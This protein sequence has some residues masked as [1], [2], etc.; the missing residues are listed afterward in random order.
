MEASL[1]VPSSLAGCDLRAVSEAISTTFISEGWIN[2]NNFL[3]YPRV[4]FSDVMNVR[5]LIEGFLIQEFNN[6]DPISKFYNAVLG[7]FDVREVY[8]SGKSY[9]LMTNFFILM[10][11]LKESLIFLVPSEEEKIVLTSFFSKL[12]EEGTIDTS[13]K[14]NKIKKIF[15]FDEFLTLMPKLRNKTVEGLEEYLKVRTDSEIKEEVISDIDLA[16]FEVSNKV[17]EDKKPM[18]TISC[19]GDNYEKAKI[20][21]I[22]YAKLNPL[23]FLYWDNHSKTVV[24][25]EPLEVLLGQPKIRSVCPLENNWQKNSFFG[26]FGLPSKTFWG[27]FSKLSCRVQNQLIG[28]ANRVDLERDKPLI[29]EFAVRVELL[30]TVM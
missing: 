14:D 4:N 19:L 6:S 26:F 29:Q 1:S 10:K 15:S 22:R 2:R 21:Y 8:V 5:R 3:I 23:P 27:H 13:E 24:S 16:F 11:N 30:S 12:S 25:Y 28:L 20:N 17:Q 18:L 9:S 7:N